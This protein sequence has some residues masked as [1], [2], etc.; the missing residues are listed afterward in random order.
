[1]RFNYKKLEDDGFNYKKLKDVHF[2]TLLWLIWNKKENESTFLKTIFSL[3]AASLGKTEL[4]V[5][6]REMISPPFKDF[7]KEIIS[8]VDRSKSDSEREV[9]ALALDKSFHQKLLIF[10]QISQIIIRNATIMQLN[11]IIG[12][13]YSR[14][15]SQMIENC[16]FDAA[17][18]IQGLAPVSDGTSS[19]LSDIPSSVAS[20]ATA[21][22]PKPV[23]PVMQSARADCAH[24]FF[25]YVRKSSL[26]LPSQHLNSPSQGTP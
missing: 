11:D 20:S 4:T 13:M 18:S 3:V 9:L 8:C 2:K 10:I 22:D 14:Q 17:G 26:S 23:D 15:L 7:Y 5:D 6:E 19:L 25:P 21:P 1:M 12:Q 16:A 24:A